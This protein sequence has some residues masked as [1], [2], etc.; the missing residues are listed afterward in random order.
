MWSKVIWNLVVDKQMNLM[1]TYSIKLVIMNIIIIIDEHIQTELKR[2]CIYSYKRQW[3]YHS[4]SS[5]SSSL[6]T[7]K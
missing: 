4:R 5:R 2:C 7:Q 1:Q 3:F 6:A